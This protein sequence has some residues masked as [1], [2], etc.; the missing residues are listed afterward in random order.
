[1]PQKTGSAESQIDGKPKGFWDFLTIPFSLVNKLIMSQIDG[2]PKGF[3][4]AFPWTCAFPETRVAN[5]RKTER[6]L[7]LLQTVVNVA[8]ADHVANR[9]K[10]ERLLRL[11]SEEKPLSFHSTV[12]NR[13]KAERLLRRFCNHGTRT[14]PLRG[15]KSTES[16]KAF[17]TYGRLKQIVP[18]SEMS[19]IDGKPKGFWDTFRFGKF[20]NKRGG[21]KSTESRKAFETA[22]C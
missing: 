6:L 16:R 15:R 10:A 1:M 14:C 5:R 9:R 3:W 11:Y 12:A 8:K 4:D 2:K 20:F 7:R 22:K 13:R 17:E 19:Q 21:R 18:L